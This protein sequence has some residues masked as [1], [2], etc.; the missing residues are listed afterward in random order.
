MSLRERLLIRHFLRRFVEHDLVSSNADRREVLS[1]AGGVLISVSLFLAVLVAL[2]YQ[3]SNFLP[4]GLTS[5]RSI[6]DRFLFVSASML[7]MAL[8]AV[9]VWDA[10]ALEDRDTAVLGVL[11][12]PLSVIVRTKVIAVALLAAV[13]AAAWN[14]PSILLRSFSLPF[15]LTVGLKGSLILTAGHAVAT[16]A[17]GAFGFLAVFAL[18]EGLAAVLGHK[19]F[20]AISAALQAVLVVVLMSALLLLPGS[21]RDVARTWLTSLSGWNVALP[22]LWFVGLHETLAGSVVDDL[23]RKEQGWLG[24]LL[25]V[26]ELLATN[27]YRSLWPQYHR[28]GRIALMMLAIVTAVTIVSCAWNNRRLPAPVVR[29]RGGMRRVR[30]A[31]RWIVARVLAPSSLQQAGFWFTM[32][33]LPRRATHRA[34]LASAVAIGV[35]LMV[36]TIRGEVLAAQ[37]LLLAAVITGFRHA[38]QLPAELRASSTFGLAWSG[39]VAPYLS[40]VKRAGY[41]A[42]VSPVIGILF[43]WHAVVLG[44]R[45]ATLHLGVGVAIS[46]LMIELLFFRYRRLPL[47]SGYV[48]MPELRSRAILYAGVVLSASFILAWI[49]RQ[50]LNSLPAYLVFVGVLAGAGAAVAAADRASRA[51][52]TVLELNEEA[53]LPTQRLDLAG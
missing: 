19:G 10:L 23:P 30:S 32:Q 8:L 48:P 46:A 51:S 7:V 17:A 45:L 52:E 47:A 31:S 18:R 22:P 38:V 40:G 53:A 6:D 13:T 50:T 21:A 37:T 41:V 14:L 1:V 49:E 16:L 28:L 11:P 34:V 25:R 4:P 20:R 36:V 39:D 5:V 42:L 24:P 35:S 29:R 3:F 43:L 27:L 44:I 15:T 26:P 33:T 2:G 9:A 12:V